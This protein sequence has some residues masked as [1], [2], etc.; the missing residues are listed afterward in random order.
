M[1]EEAL[2]AGWAAHGVPPLYVRPGALGT[3][4]GRLAVG[5][6]IQHALVVTDRG[7]G[8]AGWADRAARSIRAAGAMAAVWDLVQPDPADTIVHQCR[9]TVAAGSHDGLIAVGGG[10]CIDVAKAAAGLHR[11][12]GRLADYEGLGRLVAP[13]LPVVAVPTTPCGGAELSR[14]AVIADASGRKYAVSGSHLAPRA[15][16]VDPDTFATAPRDV[17]VN[18]ILDSLIH[19]IEAFLARAATPYTDIF[20]H[21]AVTAIAKEARAVLTRPGPP[22][23]AAAGLV[24]GC[25]AASVAMAEANAGVIHALGY[26]LT[27]E[28]GIPHGRANALMAGT[29]LRAL[30]GARPDRCAELAGAWPG[31]TDLAGAFEGLL[32]QLGVAPSLAGYGVARDR[33]PV[34]ASLAIG[35]EPVLRNTPLR[36]TEDTLAKMYDQAWL[37]A[38]GVTKE[39]WS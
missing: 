27:S 13:G 39:S 10:S 36:L 23:G 4:V 2:T 20:A 16:V 28:Y 8:A 32:G 21:A 35:Y 38:A 15:V 5:L 18:T 14:H 1:A 31:A 37:S 12:G 7:V 26:P 22:A 9:D 3:E 19:A 30:S 11:A 33:L 24:A 29:A 25:L 17:L 34:L 6:G